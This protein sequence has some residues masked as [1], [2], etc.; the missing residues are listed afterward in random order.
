M[1]YNSDTPGAHE[2]NPDYPRCKTCRHFEGSR[3]K[4]V[5][6]GHCHRIIETE[7]YDNPGDRIFDEVYDHAVVGPDFGCVHWEAKDLSP[8]VPDS[9]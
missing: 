4:D 8:T 7:N 1:A 2:M 6:N 9:Q 5:L 3:Y